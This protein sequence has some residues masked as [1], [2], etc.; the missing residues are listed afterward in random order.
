MTLAGAACFDDL[1]APEP[2]VRDAAA[3]ERVGTSL[4]DADLPR[5]FGRGFFALAFD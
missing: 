5:P 2:D 3:E 4:A 1:T